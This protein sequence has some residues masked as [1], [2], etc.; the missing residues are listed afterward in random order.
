MDGWMDWQVVDGL[1]D[2]QIDKKR[3]VERERE[4]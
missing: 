1:T 3:W 4:R 2:R